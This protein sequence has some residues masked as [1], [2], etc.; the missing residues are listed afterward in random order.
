MHL[1][2]YCYDSNIEFNNQCNTN[3]LV[4]TNLLI[5]LVLVCYKNCTFRI[6]SISDLWMVIQNFHEHIHA[7]SYFMLYVNIYAI[8]VSGVSRSRYLGYQ[9]YWKTHSWIDVYL[10]KLRYRQDMTLNI[11]TRFWKWQVTCNNSVFYIFL[12]LCLDTKITAAKKLDH[13]K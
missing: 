9:F 6:T 2:D 5:Y 10:S 4:Y 1:L 8:T 12:T 11:A 13:A 7:G 3:S